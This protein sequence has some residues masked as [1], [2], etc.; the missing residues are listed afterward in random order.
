MKPRR[1]LTPHETTEILDF[2]VRDN[3]LAVLSIAEGE[4]WH[5]A[6]CRFLE[7]DP[8]RR[9]FVLEQPEPSEEPVNLSLGQYI[10]VSF[11]YRSRK[12]M[13]ATVVEAKGRFMI[14]G[15]SAVPAIRFRWPDSLT[16]LQR[17]AY[18]RTPL[19]PGMTVPV[20]FWAGGCQAR[21][22]TQSQTLSVFNGDAL[23]I[24]CGG[25]LVRLSQTTPSEW[26]EDMTLGV[27]M[28]MPDGRPP[29]LIDAYFRGARKESSGEISAALQFVGLEVTVDGRQALQRLARCV[30][31]FHRMTLTPGMR[32]TT[33]RFLINQPET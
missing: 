22:R 28:H 10:G 15:S 27:E 13:F 30:Q 16:E 31:R 4:S 7:R 32:T 14:D 3:A 24:S 19:P 9:F 2:A 21:T 17:R 23:D 12:I 6:K 26:V 18:Y 25:T 33:A 20:S 8:N 1:I 29:L 11:R 5:T